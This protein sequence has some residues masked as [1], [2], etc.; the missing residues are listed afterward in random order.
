MKTNLGK[1]QNKQNPVSVKTGFS[2]VTHS[3]LGLLAIL[4]QRLHTGTMGN[5]PDQ[6]FTYLQRNLQTVDCRGQTKHEQYPRVLLS[7]HPRK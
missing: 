6:L 1:T 3:E 7:P 4:L 2:S 5:A